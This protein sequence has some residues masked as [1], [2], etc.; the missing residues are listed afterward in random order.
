MSYPPGDFSFK[1]TAYPSADEL[2]DAY[3]AIT[4]AEAWDLMAQEPGEGGY[5]YSQ[6][7]NLAFVHSHMK[8]LDNHSGGSY[9][10]M[11]RQMQYIA[12]HGWANYVITM[13]RNT[14]Q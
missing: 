3:D 11:M 1:T 12:K 7:P 10:Q 2:K 5:M 8:L 14:P 9:G 13:L 6:T 4:K